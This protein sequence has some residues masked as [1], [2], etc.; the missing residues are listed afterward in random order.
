ML[1]FGGILT[2][3]GYMVMS[4]G[5][6]SSW[7]MILFAFMVVGFASGGAFVSTLGAG[8]K[9]VSQNPGTAV[10]VIGGGMSL[11]M[12]FVT[13]VFLVLREVGCDGTCDDGIWRTQL[14]V[15]SIICAVVQIPSAFVFRI[16]DEPAAQ[17]KEKQ[18]VIQIT[19][20]ESYNSFNQRS[21]DD[22]EADEIPNISSPLTTEGGDYEEPFLN[23]FRILKGGFF[24]CISLTYMTGVGGS[25]VII[26][27]MTT[28]WDEFVE[29]SDHDRSNWIFSISLSFSL[30][31]CFIGGML[32]GAVADHMVNGK[33]IP[34][35]K[36]VAVVFAIFSVI[37]YALGWVSIVQAPSSFVEILFMLLLISC[38]IPFGVFVTSFPTIVGESYPIQNFGINLGLVQISIGVATFVVPVL[39]TTV[40]N[41]TG[42]YALVFLLF[43]IGYFVSAVSLFFVNP[44]PPQ[45]IEQPADHSMTDF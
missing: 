9:I 22:E 24:W 2:S 13:V 26:T 29:G 43:A 11:S 25:L 38:G 41:Q 37:F 19:D 17:T 21:D 30:V 27:Q 16:L 31:N 28:I 32:F 3:G 33:G 42:N 34:R 4:F 45:Q 44:P 20:K 40:A 12:A 15:L 6:N 1:F 10:A 35:T 36:V 39:C 7:L 5:S 23:K 8:I 14:R 18:G